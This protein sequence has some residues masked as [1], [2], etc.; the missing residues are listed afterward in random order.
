[1][2][3]AGADRAIS[4]Y[5]LSGHRMALLCVRPAVTRFLDSVSEEFRF[6]EIRIPGNSPI[7]G[8]DLKGSGIRQVANAI[9]V[10]ILNKGGVMQP[11]PGPDSKMDAGDT[12]ILLGS[13]EQLQKVEGLVLGS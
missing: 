7:A 2:K 11:N 4:P 8:K 13:D 10:A 3:K 5:V 9:V 6:E 12:L 1:M